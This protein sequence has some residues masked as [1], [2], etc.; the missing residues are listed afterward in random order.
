MVTRARSPVS[1]TSRMSASAAADDDAT[2]E[3]RSER[4][5]SARRAHAS[6]APRP[7]NAS[8]GSHPVPSTTTSSRAPQPTTAH[9]RVT[10]RFSQCVPGRTS[11]MGSSL[12]TSAS[13]FGRRDA[14]SVAG[15]ARLMPSCT[16]GYSGEGTTA[17]GDPPRACSSNQRRFAKRL[18]TPRHDAHHSR[19]PPAEQRN[20]AMRST[21]SSGSSRGVASLEGRSIATARASSRD[22]RPRLAG[23]R[24]AGCRTTTGDESAERTCERL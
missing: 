13:S 7:A 10:R 24:A 3:G 17:T 1:R 21:S 16:E 8:A 11:T 12:S 9:V 18:D 2:V 20:A 14:D 4:S 15:G 22:A 23:K 6:L 5:P 19:K